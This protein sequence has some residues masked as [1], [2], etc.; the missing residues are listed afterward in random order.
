MLPTNYR[1]AS[2]SPSLALPQTKPAVTAPVPKPMTPARSPK[3]SLFD[4]LNA[5]PPVQP[6]TSSPSTL[7]SRADQSA[8]LAETE[9]EEDDTERRLRDLG[10]QMAA[11]DMAAA[12]DSPPLSELAT[13]YHSSPPSMCR[14]IE[15]KPIVRVTQDVWNSLMVQITNLKKE[16]MDMFEKLR[17][18]QHM[19]MH[20]AKDSSQQGD[21]HTIAELRYQISANK[22]YKTEMGRMI[23]QKDDELCKKDIDVKVLQE[24]LTKSEE[25]AM[26][27]ARVIASKDK[28]ISQLTFN[29][30]KAIEVLQQKFAEA[31]RVI[32]SKDKEIA[33]FPSNSPK[34]QTSNQAKEIDNLKLQI[35]RLQNTSSD[36]AKRAQNLIETQS[37]RERRIKQL[38]EQ[39]IESQDS[40]N[41]FMDKYEKLQESLPSRHAQEVLQV[42]LSEKS[43]EA[44]RFRNDIRLLNRRFELSQQNLKK[45]EGTAALRGA[46]HLIVPANTTLPQMVFPCIECF[47]KNL[48]CDNGTRCKQCTLSGQ[49]CAR[50]RCS[51][52]HITQDC[53][54]APCRF[55]HDVNGWVMLRQKRAQW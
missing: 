4:K 6:R 26:A 23:I 40:L 10:A 47:T 45:A 19:Q 55:L 21:S 16:K 12:P 54:E 48:D 33:Q 15:E 39:L 17:R 36:Q 9:F 2:N 44:D 50:W 37:H 38:E 29:H 34:Q 22:T 53:D 35:A 43:A 5:F 1:S 3:T 51:I 46:A 8:T 14:E 52:K 28:E 11:F 20:C 41:K 31:T 25:Q 30:Q 7:E 27:T 18:T 42:K 49:E 32:S 24:N 13:D